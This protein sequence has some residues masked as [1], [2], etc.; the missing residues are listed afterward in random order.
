MYY[1]NLRLNLVQVS[2]K[3]IKR[4]EIRLPDTLFERA[5][6]A[7]ETLGVS[8]PAFAN[9]AI[10]AYVKRWKPPTDNANLWP[11]CRHCSHRHDPRVHGI[12]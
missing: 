3:E 9:L 11:P 12:D 1:G 2:K 5:S 6:F 7:A 8:L 10:A 4:L